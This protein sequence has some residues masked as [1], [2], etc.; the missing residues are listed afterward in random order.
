MC[1]V[2]GLWY[3]WY[4]AHVL[5]RVFSSCITGLLLAGIA[6]S[7]QRLA[8]GWAVRRSNP[9]GGEIFHNLPER[10]W[11]PP[12][13]LYNGYR[14]FPGSKAVG[15]WRW[16]PTPSSAKVKERVELYLYFPSGPS[17]PVL[18]RTLPSTFTFITG[19]SPYFNFTAYTHYWKGLLVIRGRIGSCK[20]F[21]R[22]SLV[23]TKCVV[24]GFIAYSILRSDI[25]GR[26]KYEYHSHYLCRNDWTD[27][28]F[29]T[30]MCLSSNQ[31]TIFVFLLYH[32]RFDC[33]M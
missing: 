17:W 6:Q 9:G 15:T 26:I 16:P 28:C 30:W 5:V 12:S 22:I 2:I 25:G 14:V 13:L 3:R 4:L 18:G 11:D 19:I 32:Y 10:T 33:Y 20:T 7:V 21:R 8:T 31:H 27:Q 29:W 23:M 24:Q 1:P